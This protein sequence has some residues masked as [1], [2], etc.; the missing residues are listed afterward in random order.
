MNLPVIPC[1]QKT[2]FAEGSVQP[3]LSLIGAPEAF[4]TAAAALADHAGRAGL[5]DGTVS[6]TLSEDASLSGEAYRI[7]VRSDGITVSASD[8]FGAHRGCAVLFQLAAS[9]GVPCGEF[10]GAPDSGFRAVMIDLARV[11]HP[12]DTVLQY[13]DMCWLYG[14]RSLHLHFTDDESYTLPS[15]RFPKLSTPGRSYTRKQIDELVAYAGTSGVEIIPE[16]DVPGHCRS[17]NEGYPELFGTNGIIPQTLTAMT[18]MQLLFSE[19]C[20]MFS[21]SAVIHIGGDEADI[22]KWTADP[23]C[24]DYAEMCGIDFDEPDKRL[25]A[26]RM[27]A[28]FVQKMADAIV[29]CGK[30]PAAWEGFGKCVNGFVSRDILLYSW[31]NYYQYTAELLEAGFDIVNASWDPMYVVPPHVYWSRE[32]IFGWDLTRWRAIHPK[33]PYKGRTV[34]VPFC[35]QIKGGELLAWGSSMER[36]YT[37]LREGVAEEQRLVEERA[38]VLSERTW[39]RVPLRTAEEALAAADAAFALLQR[40]KQ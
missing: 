2:R 5:K 40:I 37:D 20:E 15:K 12:F 38:A 34:E 17:F 18:A 22:A 33:S 23:A 25:L 27:L 36:G 16:I 13:V 29:L 9:G 39:S 6:V 8:G 1:P 31:E 28:N 7:T 26:E 4:D 10:A 35:P 11:W 32:E 14:I 24:R 19:L 30:K 3:D 21:T